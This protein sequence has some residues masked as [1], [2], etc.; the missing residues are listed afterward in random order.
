VLR[1]GTQRYF[2]LVHTYYF[3]L[4][5]LTSLLRKAGFEIVAARRRPAMLSTSDAL[6]P[7]NYWSGE[8]DVLGRKTADV[9]LAEA[10]AH[11]GTGDAPGE[12]AALL[13]AAQ[14]RDEHY[15]RLTALYRVPAIGRL[16]NHLVRAGYKLTGRNTK[17]VDFHTAQIE[18]LA[19]E[20][21]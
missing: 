3:T 8:L 7:G 16:A 4:A 11:A 9:S 12:S 17:R 20:G 21:K 15:A 2:K 6:R 10:H 18:A 5:T 19:A 1:K 13:A 14:T